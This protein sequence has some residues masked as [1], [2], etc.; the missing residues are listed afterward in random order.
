MYVTEPF[1]AKI[2][3]TLNFCF[4]TSSIREYIIFSL[5]GN[6]IFYFE[7]FIFLFIKKMN[8]KSEL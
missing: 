1:V 3:I 6:Y 7:N 8:I 2:N 5:S 4:L